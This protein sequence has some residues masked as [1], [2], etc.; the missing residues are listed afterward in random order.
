MIDFDYF[1]KYTHNAF[2]FN[3]LGDTPLAFPISWNKS[4]LDGFSLRFN[5]PEYHGFRWYTTLGHTRARLRKTDELGLL[6]AEALHQSIL[7]GLQSRERRGPMRHHGRLLGGAK[8]ELG[9]ELL[10]FFGKGRIVRDD[11]ADVLHRIRCVGD[12]DRVKR[13]DG[14]T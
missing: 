3:V 9:S 7:I 6:F 1:W 5:T 13:L 12:R 8:L 11:G 10:R 4:K 14:A 2:D